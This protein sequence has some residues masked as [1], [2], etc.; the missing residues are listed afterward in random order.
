[1][2][3]MIRNLIIYQLEFFVTSITMLQCTLII[4]MMINH[5]QYYAEHGPKSVLCDLVLFVSDFTMVAN[6]K[7]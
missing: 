3:N 6:L 5:F 4:V 7:I 2:K 1:M